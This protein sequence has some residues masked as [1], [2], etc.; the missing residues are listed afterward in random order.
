MDKRVF[1]DGTLSKQ[2]YR[3]LNSDATYITDVG[4][5]KRAQPTS[6]ELLQPAIRGANSSKYLSE[7]LDKVIAFQNRSVSSGTTQRTLE[8]VLDKN[9]YNNLMRSSVNHAG[10]K[11]VD[12]VKYNFE[13]LSGSAHRNIGVPSTKLNEFN[14]LI[15]EI[16]EYVRP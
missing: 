12:A 10:S 13:G 15:L 7:S 1:C 16:R 5:T 8:F 3:L 6:Y 11:G 4:H 14:R 9:G 2:L